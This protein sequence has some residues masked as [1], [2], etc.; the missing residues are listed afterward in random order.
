MPKNSVAP[1]PPCIVV[2]EV[3]GREKESACV[4]EKMGQ[5][6]IGREKCR[7]TNPVKF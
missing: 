4:G 1:P 3:K 7:T 6:G 2:V 5:D